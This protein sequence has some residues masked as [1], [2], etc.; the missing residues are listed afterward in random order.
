MCAAVLALVIQGTFAYLV[1][2]FAAGLALNQRI[3]GLASPLPIS[4]LSRQ[5]GDALLNGNGSAVLLSLAFTLF[6]ALFATALT[7]LNNGVRVSFS[8]SLDNEMPGILSLL[9]PRF[10]T[11]YV[12]V[13][14]L[15]GVSALIGAAGLLGGLPVLMGLVLASNLGAVGLYAALSVLAIIAYHRKPEFNFFRH[16]LLPVLGLM[17]NLATAAA[18][19]FIGISSGGVTA[20]ASIFALGVAGAWLLVSAVYSFIRPR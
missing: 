19:P 1:G 3:L 17:A 15:G 20:Q 9:H 12:T 7:A 14:L 4:D 16:L 13:L 10:A 5:A 6:L 8:I 18:F 11:P 2:Y